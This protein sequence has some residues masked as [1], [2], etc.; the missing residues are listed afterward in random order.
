[1][2]GASFQKYTVYLVRGQRAKPLLMRFAICNKIFGISGITAPR[3][4]AD[5][6]ERTAAPP[7]G[8]LSLLFNHRGMGKAA[9]YS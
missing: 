9:G 2:A 7:A 6:R 1:M 4:A 3:R 8:I 5:L